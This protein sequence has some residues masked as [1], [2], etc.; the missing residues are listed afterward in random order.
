MVNRYFEQ[1]KGQRLLPTTAA[2]PTVDQ[3]NKSWASG[4]NEVLQPPR[5]PGNLVGQETV[6]LL[7][8]EMRALG[9]HPW[10]LTGPCSR[11]LAN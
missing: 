7:S 5:L 1:P 10:L 6:L 8:S 9:L 11:I 2:L 4:A 3:L